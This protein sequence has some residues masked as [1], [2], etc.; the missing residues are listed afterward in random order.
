MENR[1]ENDVYRTEQR[2]EDIPEDVARWGG[3]REEDVQRFDNRVE[4]AW[5]EGRREERYD[6]Y[7]RD[8]YNSRDDYDRRDDRFEERVE[9][10]RYDDRRNDGY[11]ERVEIDRYEE[12]RDDW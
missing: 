7:R 1:V 4:N 6:D 9:V 8:D 5:D 10:D 3:R 11:E 2:V 12:R